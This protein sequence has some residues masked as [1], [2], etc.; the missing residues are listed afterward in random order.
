MGN[1]MPFVETIAVFA[2]YLTGP[3]AYLATAVALVWCFIAEA[4]SDG[5]HM[6]RPIKMIFWS[7]CALGTLQ[8]LALA[9]PYHA[10]AGLMP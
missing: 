10:A 9:F 4:M 5:G 6:Q 3:W 2:K 1:E 8:I 7:A